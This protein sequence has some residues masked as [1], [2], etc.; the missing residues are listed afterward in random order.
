MAQT[1]SPRPQPKNF[2][3]YHND[4]D[5]SV[6]FHGSIAIDCEAM[7][8]NIKRDRL[9]LIQIADSD[10]NC[11]IIQFAAQPQPYAAAPHLQSLFEDSTITKIFHYAR[12]DL[13][14]IYHYLGIMVR[15]IYCTR[16]ASKLARTYT[17]KHGLR[18]LCKDLLGF[19]L[20]K[21]KQSSDWG[22]EHLAN[23]QL[24]YA[25]HD[26]IHLHTLRKHLDAMLEREGRSPLAAACFDFLPHRALLDLAGWEDDIFSHSGS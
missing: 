16:T 14:C 25:C 23:S 13:A 17:D 2:H 11:H 19:D 18:A 7:G 1:I 3:V 15:S 9:C 20:S 5:A 10:S 8:L 26:V 4:L 6:S 22:K 21:Q 12:F 24:R